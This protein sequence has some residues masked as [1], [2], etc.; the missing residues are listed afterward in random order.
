M[1]KQVEVGSVF[2]HRHNPGYC[3]VTGVNDD[4][5]TFRVGPVTGNPAYTQVT[6]RAIFEHLV[7]MGL[8]T[9]VASG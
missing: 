2:T 5:V 8:Y 3:T 6:P 9:Q 7:S 4:A 1:S